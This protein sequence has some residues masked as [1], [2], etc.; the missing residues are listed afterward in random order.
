[1]ERPP[2]GWRQL[3]A[4][5][6]EQIEA[7]PTIDNGEWA[8]RIKERLVRLGFAY[9]DPPDRLTDAMDAVERALEKLWGPRPIHLPPTF[10]QGPR[11]EVLHQ[12]DPPW[13]KSQAPQEWTSLKDLLGKLKASHSS[14]KSSRT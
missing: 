7:E 11:R 12:V 8:E 1:M 2:I 6:R 9:P 4:I 3:C 14:G 13:P 10:R 5:T